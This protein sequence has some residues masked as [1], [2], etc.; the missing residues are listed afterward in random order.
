LRL[1]VA[2]GVDGRPE[3]AGRMRLG[4]GSPTC[5][6]LSTI[7]KPRSG[8][9]QSAWFWDLVRL[10]GTVA[11]RCRRSLTLRFG[12]SSESS[13]GHRPTLSLLLPPIVQ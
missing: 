2:D 1:R 5:W 7:R 11:D 8:G 9:N 10:C 13:S 4:T 6:I 3:V 12:I